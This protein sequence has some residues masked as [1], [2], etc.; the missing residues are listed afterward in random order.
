MQQ[1]EDYNYTF[2]VSE[3][4]HLY[5]ILFILNIYYRFKI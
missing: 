1:E 2:Q 4:Y 5:E 3:F